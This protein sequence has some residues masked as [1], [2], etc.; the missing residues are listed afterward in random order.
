MACSPLTRLPRAEVARR[1]WKF[2]VFRT[3]L[4]RAARLIT[5]LPFTDSGH[6]L[7]SSATAIVTN[8]QNTAVLGNICS[9][10]MVSAL[11]IYEAAGV[12]TISGSATSSVL[13][14]LGPTVF[15][16]TAVVS[17][18]SGDAG[19]IWPSSRSVSISMAAPT[20]VARSSFTRRVYVPSKVRSL[21]WAS[22]PE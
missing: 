19:D 13:P 21:G 1:T 20:P 10:G 8:T 7:T 18:A 14:A 15:N 6:P 2:V 4:A 17:D 11:P 16:R 12:V 9:V 3:A 5:R 22:V